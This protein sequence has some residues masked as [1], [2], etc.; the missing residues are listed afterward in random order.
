MRD[1]RAVLLRE[2]GEIQRADL[3]A[4]KMC[5]HRQDRA[6]GD[7]AAAADAGEQGATVRRWAASARQRPPTQ[8][9]PALPSA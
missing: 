8:L 6:G 3:A 7:D 9:L 1:D 2:P 5:R 4:F